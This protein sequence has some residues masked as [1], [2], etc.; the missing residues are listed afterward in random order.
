MARRARISTPVEED[1]QLEEE[2]PEA[3]RTQRDQRHVT[4]VASL[5]PSPAASFSSDKENRADG[6][7]SAR[8]NNGKS[9][10][11]PPPKLPT[12]SSTEPATPRASKRR[13]LSERGI[14]NASQMAHQKQLEALGDREYYDP[15]QSMEE[16]RGIRKEIR[17]LS[18]ELNG[19][20]CIPKLAEIGLDLSNSLQTL[21]PNIWH[22]ARMVCSRQS[23]RPT[24]Y[25]FRSS[26]HRTRL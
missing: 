18:R 7:S 9:K 11:M 21:A 12:P 16:R 5:S 19:T 13:K 8:K 17:D 24:I 20:L 6:N 4:N 23:I 15:D 3:D 22:P 1:E 10:A 25:L 26:R 2:Y 14:P